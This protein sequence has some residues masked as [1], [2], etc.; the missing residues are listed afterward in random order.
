[1]EVYRGQNGFVLSTTN[2]KTWEKIDL[3]AT[4][5]LFKVRMNGDLG[6]IIGDYGTILVTY[7]GG[8]TWK[9]FDEIAKRTSAWLIDM[10]P[11]ASDKAAVILGKGLLERINFKE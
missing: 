10:Y 4:E 11:M 7:D 9:R 2:G 8:N 3:P 6:V 1:M 5:S